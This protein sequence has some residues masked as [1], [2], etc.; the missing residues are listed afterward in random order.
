MYTF[1]WEGGKIVEE[2]IPHIPDFDWRYKMNFLGEIGIKG[3]E[4]LGLMI[5]NQW[6]VTT[7][8]V[9]FGFQEQV[10]KMYKRVLFR[11]LIHHRIFGRFFLRW[12]YSL[13]LSRY[14][15]IYKEVKN[16]RN[17]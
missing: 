11:L 16:E 12:Y 3:Y 8:D 6:A 9:Y 7:I 10:F 17:K 5:I 2:K 15:W 14:W 1:E 13:L 4:M